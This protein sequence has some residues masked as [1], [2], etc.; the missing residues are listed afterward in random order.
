M[1]QARLPK[2]SSGKA[3]G[4]WLGM[5][6]VGA[7]SVVI[8]FGVFN[9][10]LWLGVSPGWANLIA[11]AVATLAAFL[12]N[13]SWTFRH[14]DVTKP[15]RALL[16]FFAVNV[17]SAAVVQLA[18]IATAQLTLDPAWLNAIKFI[19]TAVVTII[20]FWLYRSHVFQVEKMDAD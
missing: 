6:V 11:L 12:G 19:A 20:R 10:L 4:E 17:G 13:F 8:D 7:V 14:R 9:V 1:T 16:L 3:T 18:V 15:Q 2:K 5:A